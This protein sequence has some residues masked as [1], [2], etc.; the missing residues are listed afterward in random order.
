M[1]RIIFWL[2]FS[3]VSARIAPAKVFTFVYKDYFNSA[4]DPDTRDDAIF[5][6]GTNIANATPFPQGTPFQVVA[7]FDS[8][9]PDTPPH[10]ISPGMQIYTPI[11]ATLTVFTQGESQV[12][13]FVENFT[14]P[15]HANPGEN[16]GDLHRTDIAIFDGTNT[17]IAGNSHAAIGMIE[18]PWV[19]GAGFIGDFTTMASHSMTVANLLPNTFLSYNGTG[20]Q[21]GPG[22]PLYCGIPI[23]NQTTVP[24]TANYNE[25]IKLQGS[26]GKFYW[27]QLDNGDEQT[28]PKLQASAILTN[29]LGF[30]PLSPCRVID[31]RQ[32]NGGG[33]LAA[34]TLRDVDF[35][36]STCNIPATAQAYS[37]NATVVPPQPLGYLTI[38]AT[39]DSLPTTSTLN[40]VDGRIKSN[41]A[42]I[43][44]GTGGRVSFYA[45]APTDL[46]VD[47]NGYFT[48][49]ATDANS[50]SFYPL[51]PCRIIDTRNA[52][53]T[54]GGPSLM[55]GVTRTIP[56]LSSPCNVPSTAQAYSMNYTVVPQGSLGYL[57]TWPGDVAMP[58]VSTLNATTGIV[59][60]N[61]AIVPA[62]ND[63][64]IDVFASRT[65]DLVIDIN[66]YFA[67]TAA[68][69]QSLY[70][71]QSCRAVDSRTSG[72]TPQAGTTIL[73]VNKSLCPIPS[74]A[75][76]VLTNAT[77]V[78]VGTLGYLTLWPD[79]QPKPL[80][81]TLNAVDGKV[82]SNMAIV[83]VTDGSIDAYISNPSQGIL[84][85]FGYF[86]P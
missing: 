24:C 49:V 70:T 56:V 18:D 10:P 44:A 13:T 19:D 5:L 39:G 30:H 37:I 66:G 3:A 16:P 21:P 7:T 52:T 58:L 9:V 23:P 77:V 42:I 60:A 32:P 81:S 22:T 20:F 78:P 12:Y 65:T 63:G 79:G 61:A 67:P 11:T 33:Q 54:F 53:G 72:N 71:F 34:Q 1:K 45:S 68:G 46:I 25:P 83:P 85:V 38:L 36:A 59:T 27:L 50:L 6:D 48:S 41:A 15:Y 29:A 75:Q 64:S 80:A 35:L 76:G 84:D 28:G 69:G 14:S 86:A 2:A 82:T 47:I 57:T 51:A 55:G 17:A 4:T 74:V 31:T 43:Q 73:P 8:S 62:S 40:S 26:D